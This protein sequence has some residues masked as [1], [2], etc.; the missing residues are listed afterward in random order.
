VRQPRIPEVLTDGLRDLL[1]LTEDHATRERRVGRRHPGGD[2]P[3]G[4]DPHAIEQ[5][6]QPSS[7]AARGARPVEQQLGRDPAPAEVGGEI[8]GAVAG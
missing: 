7:A 2:G 6:G 1:V 3:L 8:E 5:A 4:P